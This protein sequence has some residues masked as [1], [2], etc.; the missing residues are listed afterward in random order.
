MQL[1][2]RGRLM[3]YAD[4][5]DAALLKRNSLWHHASPMVLACPDA[6]VDAFDICFRR[7]HA[8]L[9]LLT[10]VLLELPVTVVKGAHLAG[11]EPAGDAVEVESV[12]LSQVSM[13][14]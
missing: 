9:G 13:V 7:C 14:S 6:V 12:L 8:D 10:A 5:G 3:D 11:L 2:E 4:T 1:S